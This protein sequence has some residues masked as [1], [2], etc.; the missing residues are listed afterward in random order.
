MLYLHLNHKKICINKICINIVIL[1][2]YETLCFITCLINIGTRGIN[3]MLNIFSYMS[4]KKSQRKLVELHK[5]ILEG[6]KELNRLHHD[7]QYEMSHV[8]P[9]MYSYDNGYFRDPPI[10]GYR[11]SSA[12]LTDITATEQSI[13]ETEYAIK[14]VNKS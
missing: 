12:L 5:S 6:M 11:N 14:K 10:T 13:I 9:S 2:S 7:Y 3:V 8:N 4:T 1:K